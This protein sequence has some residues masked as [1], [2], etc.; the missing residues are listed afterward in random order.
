[1]QRSSGEVIKTISKAKQKSKT[2]PA[3]GV[4]GVRVLSNAPRP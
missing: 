4:V 1:M 3:S 2:K